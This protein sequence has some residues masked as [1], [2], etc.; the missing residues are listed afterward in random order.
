M[1]EVPPHVIGVFH[2]AANCH[3]R[4]VHLDVEERTWFGIYRERAREVLVVRDFDGVAHE[5]LGT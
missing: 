1:D 4:A 5:G 2:A 3:H